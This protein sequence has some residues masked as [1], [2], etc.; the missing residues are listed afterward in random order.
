MADAHR[1]EY[2]QGSAEKFLVSEYGPV[3]DEGGVWSIKANI[4]LGDLKIEKGQKY[5]YSFTINAQNGQGGE[6]LIR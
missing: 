4:G 6:I 2:M 3:R 1:H 5:Y